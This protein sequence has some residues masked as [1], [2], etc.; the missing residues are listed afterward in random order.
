ME[1]ETQD[2]LFQSINK[3]LQGLVDG[4]NFFDRTMKIDQ[5]TY[6][7]IRKIATAQ[8]DNYPTG[9]LL[10]YYYLKEHYKLIVIDLK[11]Q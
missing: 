10:G 1:K 6:D 3:W 7:N 9:C 8:R 4:Q 5:L 2:L 11:K